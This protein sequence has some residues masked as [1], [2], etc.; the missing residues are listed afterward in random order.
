[1]NSVCL[2]ASPDYVCCSKGDAAEGGDVAAIAAARNGTA[3]GVSSG[4]RGRIET[5]IEKKVGGKRGQS[6]AV[7]RFL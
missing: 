6:N 7:I 3:E 1:M 5:V 4:S 2:P